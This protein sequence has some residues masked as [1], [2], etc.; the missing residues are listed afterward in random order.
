LRKKLK[1]NISTE[2][3]EKIA[4]LARIKLSKEEKRIFTIQ[5]NGILDYFKI[6][7][8]VNTKNVKPTYHVLDMVNVK[9]KDKPE[10]SLSQKQ[11]LKNTSKKEKGFFKSSRI[12]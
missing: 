6:I 3:V 1:E 7:D 9:R 4:Q 11:V 12:M 10:K 5:F 8:E 2:E